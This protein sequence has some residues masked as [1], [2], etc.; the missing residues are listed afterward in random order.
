MSKK[1]KVHSLTGRITPELMKVAF[2]SVKK[3]RG[4]AG[5]D[6]V[7]VQMFEANLEQNLEAL[8]RDLKQGDFQAS[9]LRRVYIP[10]GPRS[11]KMRPLGIPVV[12]DRVAQEVLRR[13]LEPIFEPMFHD[14]SFGFRPRRNCHMAIEGAL[15][16]HQQGYRHVLDADIKGFFDNI[17]HQVIMNLVAE[18]VAD[19]NILE[20]IQRFLSAGVMEDGV[21]KPTTVGTPQGG[22]ISPLLANIVLNK[23]DWHL[24]HC[25][26]RFVRYADDFVVLTQSV[27]QAQEALTAV[28]YAVEEQLGLQLSQEKT[29]ISTY[30]KGYEF[31]GFFISSRSRRMRDK[32]VKKFKEKVRE[33]TQRHHNLDTEAVMKLNRVIR[34][35]A[36]YFAT[37]FSTSRWFFQKVD[38]WIRMRLR[39]MKTKRK[40]YSDNR[41]ISCRY[42]AR[43][44]GLLTLEG[45]CTTRDAHGKVHNVIPRRGATPSGAAR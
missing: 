25:R 40:N 20:L 5:V 4:A 38:S 43:A 30:G 32:S 2:K 9:P 17:P 3:N 15:A 34:G 39:C 21:F 8:M 36:N 33:L 13:L 22:V 11:Q 37:T 16:L 29:H 12:R 28:R 23:L 41:K 24:D 18:E 42:F 14:S 7:S 45:F 31:L 6:K 19:G 1:I 27:Q 10:K 26:Y 44:L 35:T